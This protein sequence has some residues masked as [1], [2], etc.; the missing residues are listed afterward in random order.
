MEPTCNPADWG[1]D[2]LEYAVTKGL[3]S[4]LVSFQWDGTSTAPDCDGPI[5][6]VQVAN[7]GSESWW[8]TLPRKRRG[9]RWIEI[10]PG[11]DATINGAALGSVGLDSAFD[12][13]GLNL[14][15]AP[16][17]PGN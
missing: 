2:H 4:I 6:F 11:T 12:I 7:T 14:Y 5:N 17:H 13:L 8:V 3:V 10:P 9:N 15:D 16:E 1:G